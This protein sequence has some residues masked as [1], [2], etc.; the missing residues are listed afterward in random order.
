[1][2]KY[3]LDEHIHPGIATGLW[4]RDPSLLILETRLEFP[5]RSDE[6]HLS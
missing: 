6:D 5:G 3:L 4:E 1:M 2:I